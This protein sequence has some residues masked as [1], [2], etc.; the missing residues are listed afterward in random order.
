[1]HLARSVGAAAAAA[2]SSLWFAR[3]ALLRCAADCVVAGRLRGA[4]WCYSPLCVCSRVAV[5]LF[6]YC[7]FPSSPLQHSISVVFTLSMRSSFSIYY[8]QSHRQSQ[9]RQKGSFEFELGVS[10]SRRLLHELE[11]FT[12]VL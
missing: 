6:F 1:M 10:M 7:W 2:C 9:M 11:F 5:G 12:H 4:P 3:T 8:R